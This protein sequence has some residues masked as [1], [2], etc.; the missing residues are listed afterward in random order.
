MLSPNW[1]NFNLSKSWKP[2]YL[3]YCYY[4]NIYKIKSHMHTNFGRKKKH[5]ISEFHISGKKKK[6]KKGLS[7]SNN[8]RS[9]NYIYILFLHSS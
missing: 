1:C 9:Y 4:Q 2:I 5:L 7:G 8:S 6:R 3:I